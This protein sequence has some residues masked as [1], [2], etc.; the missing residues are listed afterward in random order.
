M[1]RIAVRNGQTTQKEQNHLQKLSL[2]T[3][4]DHVINEVKHIRNRIFTQFRPEMISILFDAGELQAIR[5]IIGQDVE[6]FIIDDIFVLPKPIKEEKSVDPMVKQPEHSIAATLNANAYDSSGETAH[7][8]FCGGNK[9]FQSAPVNVVIV[10]QHQGAGS[11]TSQDNV[12]IRK[13]VEVKTYE[14]ANEQVLANGNNQPLE[15]LVELGHERNIPVKQLN[16]MVGC[17]ANTTPNNIQGECSAHNENTGALSLQQVS[18]SED[19]IDHRQQLNDA[20]SGDICFTENVCQFKLTF[21]Y[22]CLM[23]N[24]FFRIT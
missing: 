15:I 23:K 9:Q 19:K 21:G 7:T 18:S 6:D 16:L 1:N 11:C 10:D 20:V 8:S 2:V 5:A 17:S 22:Q 14:N 12:V 3:L 4:D 24:L 13:L